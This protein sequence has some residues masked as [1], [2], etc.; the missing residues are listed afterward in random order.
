MHVSVSQ[1]VHTNMR[2]MREIS[3]S[4]PRHGPTSGQSQDIAQTLKLRL[5]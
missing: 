1:R 3:K 2:P 4:R 5:P